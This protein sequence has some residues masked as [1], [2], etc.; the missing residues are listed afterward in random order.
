MHSSLRLTAAVA[1]VVLLTGAGPATATDGADTTAGTAPSDR[2]TPSST[3]Q[4]EDGVL[5][6]ELPHGVVSRASQ[7]ST[8]AAAA[9]SAHRLEGGTLVYWAVSSAGEEDWRPRTSARWGP[10]WSDDR[11]SLS[12]TRMT[13]AGHDSVHHPLSDGSACLCTDNS[14]PQAAADEAVV[15]YAVFP[16]IPADVDQVSVDVSGNGDWLRGIPVSEELPSLLVEEQAVV[17]GEGYPAPPEPGS[18][19][20]T[21]QEQ[22]FPARLDVLRRAEAADG[23]SAR[24]TSDDYTQVDISSEV[25]FDQHE[26]ELSPESSGVLEELASEVEAAGATEITVVGHTDSRGSHRDNQVLSEQRAGSVAQA[27]EELL[28]DVSISSEGR[29]YDEPVATNTTQE[30]MAK[31]RRVSISYLGVEQ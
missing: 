31:N 25:F 18:A 7:P 21:V 11:N 27:L 29:S 3:A 28:P 9:L 12:A 6:Y 20:I 23:L 4:T 19:G 16:E 14:A 2:T 30:G 15:V 22:R 24:T 8:W 5:A 13:L 1:A 10:A 26:F 17:L